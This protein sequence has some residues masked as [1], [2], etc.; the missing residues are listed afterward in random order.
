MSLTSNHKT[1]FTWHDLPTKPVLPSW[2]ELENRYIKV[3]SIDQ[4]RK[5]KYIG[6]YDVHTVTY[7]QTHWWRYLTNLAVEWNIVLNI[8]D[9]C[10]VLSFSLLTTSLHLYSKLNVHLSCPY[11]ELPEI[12]FSKSLILSLEWIS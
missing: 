5:R 6:S 2:T 4:M 8:W 9:L 11:T 12:N 1:I 10:H 7:T 3:H